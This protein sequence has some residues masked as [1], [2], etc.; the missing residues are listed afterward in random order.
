MLAPKN[1]FSRADFDKIKQNKTKRV[2]SQNG[3]FVFIE[4][5]IYPP[6]KTIV[7][8]KK[9]SKSAVERNNLKTM[10]HDRRKPI[11]LK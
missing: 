7:V 10:W 1:K 3:F 8:S 6:K 9:I 11:K 2:N 4:D 5:S